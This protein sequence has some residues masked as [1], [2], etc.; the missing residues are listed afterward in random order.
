MNYNLIASVIYVL[1]FSP[2]IILGLLAG[3][4]FTALKAGWSV[5]NFW[6]QQVN[7]ELEEE[8]DARSADY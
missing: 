3:M 4:L 2:V 8:E 6:V 1:L 5:W 7:E